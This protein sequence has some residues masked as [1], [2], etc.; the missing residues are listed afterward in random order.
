MAQAMQI[1]TGLPR[2]GPLALCIL[3]E[4]EVTTEGVHRLSHAIS[5]TVDSPCQTLRELQL[6]RLLSPVLQ[7]IPQQLG[8]HPFIL[9]M[10]KLAK[11]LG[12][13]YTMKYFPPWLYISSVFHPTKDYAFGL[14]DITDTPPAPETYSEVPMENTVSEP[15]LP[16]SFPST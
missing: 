3:D 13:E 14:C 4:Q 11:D 10:R 6:Y 5:T 12:S 9:R 15:P 1:C 8:L 2:P 16:T 7:F